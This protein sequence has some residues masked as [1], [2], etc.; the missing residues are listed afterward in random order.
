MAG[1]DG[2]RGLV[3]AVIA[4]YEARISAVEALF[5]AT[6]EML[7][8]FKVNR[9]KVRVEL[10]EILA[11]GETLRRK[12]FDVMMGGVLSYQE[13]REREVKS[14]IR[15]YL[16]EQKEMAAALKEG[17]A[18]GE[19]IRLEDF[20]MMIKGIQGRQ[21]EREQR[22]RKILTNFQ[23]E[24]EET[25][26][27]LR[28]LLANGESLRIKDFKATLKNIQ[29]QQKEKEKELGTMLAG[30]QKER[31]MASPMQRPASTIEKRSLSKL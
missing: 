14:A 8:G 1:A 7:E 23:R 28:K 16:R 25:V 2:M 11:K 22:V 5:E 19:S 27:E 4:S 21:E 12:D 26:R 20:R 6:H 10:R 9:E 31:E 15:Q 3:Q 13:K 24:Q 18:K 30:F 29:V 17:L